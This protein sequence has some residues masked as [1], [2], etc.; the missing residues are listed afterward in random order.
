MKIYDS[1]A[2]RRGRRAR[3]PKGIFSKI[4]GGTIAV[5]SQEGMDLLEKFKVD[6]KTVENFKNRLTWTSHL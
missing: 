3:M 1:T 4:T 2:S 6:P 5:Q